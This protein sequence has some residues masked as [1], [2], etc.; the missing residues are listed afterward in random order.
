MNDELLKISLSAAVPL[1]IMHVRSWTPERRAERAAVCGQVV[2][3]HGDVI[4]FKQ[5]A[6]KKHHIGTAEAF[7]ALAEALALLSFYPGGVKFAGQHWE[8]KS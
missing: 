8:S 3:E 1:W 7:N 4:Q 6:T 5:P 2:A